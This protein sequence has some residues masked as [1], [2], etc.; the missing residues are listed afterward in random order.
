MRRNFSLHI[1]P[2][3]RRFEFKCSLVSTSKSRRVRLVN[4]MN[5]INKNIISMFYFYYFLP[6][7]ILP[8]YPRVVLFDHHCKYSIDFLLTSDQIFLSVVSQVVR[9]VDH[10]KYLLTFA[11]NDLSPTMCKRKVNRRKF[12]YYCYK[13]ECTSSLLGFGGR[14]TIFVLRRVSEGDFN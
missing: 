2:I 6:A 12:S 4:F 9:L 13:L 3:R 14:K 11:M 5:K 7:V 1:L 8:H 10:H